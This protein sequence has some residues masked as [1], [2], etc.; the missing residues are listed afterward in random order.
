MVITVTLTSDRE[1]ALKKRAQAQADAVATRNVE[2]AAWNAANP[3]EQ[4]RPMTPVLTA[5][6]WL[7]DIV[8]TQL[9]VWAQEDYNRL[10]SKAL[11]VFPTLP[12]DVQTQIRTLIGV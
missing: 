9:N 2:A 4:P 1:S 5:E 6:E 11:E 10:A 12:P 7:A 8:H 3:K